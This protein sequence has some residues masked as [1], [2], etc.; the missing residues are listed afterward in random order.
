MTAKK[1]GR[2][3]FLYEL[4]LATQDKTVIRSELLNIRKSYIHAYYHLQKFE[5]TLTTQF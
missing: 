1:D 4:F 2:Y 5:L 3:I